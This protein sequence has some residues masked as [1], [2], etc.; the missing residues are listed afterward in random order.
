MQDK[1]RDTLPTLN[2]IPK[3]DTCVTMALDFARGALVG[4]ARASMLATAMR[5]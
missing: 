1:V 4:K 3:G 5:T 2:A